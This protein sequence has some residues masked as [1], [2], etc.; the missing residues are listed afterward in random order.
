MKTVTLQIDGKKIF[1]EAGVTILEAARQNGIEIPT[2]CYHPRLAPLGHCRICLVEVEGYSKPITSCDNPVRHGMIVNTDTAEL[3]EKRNRILAL[4]LATHPYKDCLTC[5]RT[6]TC[7]LQDNA[8]NFGVELPAQ[9]DRHDAEGPEDDNPYIV[10]DEE[11][12]ILCGRCVQICRT[13]PGCSVYSIV[14]NGVDTRVVPYRDGK[15][16]TLEEAGCV[17]CGQCVDVCPVAA[18]S[19]KKRAAVGREWELT[20]ADGICLECSLGCVL[21]RQAAKSGLVRVT[22][23]REG[24]RAGW[25]CKKGK[26]GIRENGSASHPKAL[27]LEGAGYGEADLDTVMQEVADSLLR[28]KK[29]HGSEAIALLAS[30]QQS[31]EESYLLKKLA[32]EVLGGAALDLGVEPSWANAYQAMMKICG[33]DVAGPEPVDL[34]QADTLVFI[35]KGIAESHPVAAMA[36]SRA[37]RFGKARLISIA[38]GENDGTAWEQLQLDPAP[39]QAGALLEAITL[40]LKD[41]D[42]EAAA[43][44]AGLEP[45][46]VAAA[47]ALLKARRVFSVVSPEILA[48]EGPTFTKALLDLAGVS[49]QLAAGH[50]GLLLLSSSSNAAGALQAA[51]EEVPEVAA[52]DILDAAGNRQARGLLFFGSAFAGQDLGDREFVAAFCQGQDEA[53]AGADLILPQAGSE[54][55][56]GSF[57]TSAGRHSYNLALSNGTPRLADWQ[58]ICKIAQTLGAD[59]SYNSLQEVRAEM[60]G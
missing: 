9:L 23:P 46:K 38:A 39:G 12:C 43:E 10:R 7:E 50:C 5:E 56:E 54:Y 19:E 1:A 14:G 33:P 20:H 27:R 2:L 34:I 60:K 22:V 48:A 18:L 52:G 35:G 25:L 21:Q 58:I 24:D 4:S 47:A 15:V 36:V 26:F 17:F 31:N 45:K 37:A 41:G 44:K 6:G 59:W 55:R 42:Y 40:V 53:P 11:K 57:T 30:G 13:G 51:G 16:V 3:R 29:E 28:L 32:E 49:G 8:Y